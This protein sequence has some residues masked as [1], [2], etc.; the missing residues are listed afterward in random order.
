MQSGAGALVAA[1]YSLPAELPPARP[2]Q[3]VHVVTTPRD[4]V[5]KICNCSSTPSGISVDWME[6]NRKNIRHFTHTEPAAMTISLPDL[7]CHPEL[8][9]IDLP[10]NR[11][12]LSQVGRGAY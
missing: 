6:G 5:E 9:R 2:D 1:T 11:I 4:T 7:V 10:K 12:W 3:Q 8:F